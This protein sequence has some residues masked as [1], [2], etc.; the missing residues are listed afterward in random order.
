MTLQIYHKS[1]CAIL[2]QLL[3]LPPAGGTVQGRLCLGEDCWW[4]LFGISWEG[5]ANAEKSWGSIPQPLRKA[6][7]LEIEFVDE[8]KKRKEKELEL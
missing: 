1:F 5:N 8:T 4:C 3:L 2:G 6:G 7:H